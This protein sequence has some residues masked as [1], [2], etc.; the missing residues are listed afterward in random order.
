M[1]FLK[2]LGCTV[3]LA[4]FF[5][6]CSSIAIND[7]ARF[8]PDETP[9][10]I[11][12]ARNA[13]L[14]SV[15][16]SQYLSILDDVSS[17]SIGLIE[18]IDS[19][20]AN[21]LQ[22]K[23]ILLY[24]GTDEK[25]QPI[26]IIETQS[27]FLEN[28][29]A[30]YRQAFGQQYYF[31]HQIPILKIRLR[32]QQ[33]FAAQIDE[34]LLISESSLGIENAIRVYRGEQ[35]GAQLDETSLKPGSLI[36]NTPALETW[37]TQQAKVAYYP[38]I[39][40]IF[41][42]TKLAQLNV[43]RKDSAAGGGLKLSGT[44]PISGRTKS[45]LVKAISSKN[46][47]VVL[48]KYIPLDA[49]AFA[50]FRLPP[51]REFPET[52]IDTTSVDSFF[53]NNN[54]HY[55]EIRSLLSEELAIAMFA[56]S[57][58]RSINEHAFIRKVKDTRR[59]RDL[60]NRW[61]DKGLLKKI[62]DTYFVR[63]FSLCQLIG[64][65]L[66]NFSSFYIKLVDE[67][68]VIASRRGLVEMI[69]S[70]YRRRQVVFYEPYYQKIKEDLPKEVSG[71]AIGGTELLTYLRPFLKNSSYI[72]AL[73]SRYDYISIATKKTGSEVA[74]G[75]TTYNIES[76]V[77]PFIEN[78][79]L[80]VNSALTGPPAFAD[81]QG[82]PNKEII[83]ATKA[84]K[85]YIM[86]ADGTLIQ[87]YETK[88]DTP[89]GAP[90]AFDWYNTGQKIV[91]IAAGNKIFA[92]DESGE[93]LPNFPFVLDENITTPLTVTDL[94]NNGLPDII[95]ATANRKMHV[96][97]ARGDELFG[98]PVRTNYVIDDQPLISQFQG[99]NTVTAFAS[100]AIHIWSATGRGL[101]GFPRFI[102]ASFTGS[103]VNVQGEIIGAAAD[104]S[105]YAF[106]D[107]DLFD[108]S[109]S[110]THRQL[111][112]T[113]NIEMLYTSGSALSGTPLIT[114]DSKIV[115]MSTEGSIYVFN[116]NGALLLAK[117]MGQSP[118]P[119][120]IPVVTD[121]NNDESADVVALA[122]YG[123]LYAWNLET[124][125]RINGLPTAAMSNVTVGDIDGDGLTE[126]VGRTEE[127]VRSWTVN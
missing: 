23:S 87:T 43:T 127:G 90:V 6:S 94:N 14:R 93:I 55:R 30:E 73:A 110:T 51:A 57:G 19:T 89:V 122:D 85:I 66:C 111:I 11:V 68:V 91:M 59:F 83:F 117:S 84:G 98:W 86:G 115:A 65:K 116:E 82:S 8:V 21:S 34:L 109:L 46:A 22:I 60:L 78:W 56:E 25:L 96:L 53:I 15:I 123:R 100:N 101:A 121:I 48:D 75:L 49:S 102:D 37:I 39:R 58:F 12:P 40:N 81:I 33:M 112:S 119:E 17:S 120:W 63:S 67:A 88:E 106:G 52:L 3:L 70:D 50:F 28:M 29:A 118:A 97:N 99:R 44:I 105:L 10:I 47:P 9:F 72:G 69:A 2:K 20:A 27:N 54:D 45:T 125:E 62:D 95:V 4:C 16:N 77:K 5:Y 104:G 124:G 71:F 38:A 79:V 7:W 103:P 113:G 35:P 80:P 18:H 32:Q 64:S 108:N 74:F 61:A 92:W 41:S 36:M 114:E 31:F 1:S 13:D 76:E 42:G 26:W 24:P 126:I 107:N